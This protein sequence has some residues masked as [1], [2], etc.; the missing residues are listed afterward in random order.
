VIAFA[1]SPSGLLTQVP[2]PDG[3]RSDFTEGSLE[4]D[5]ALGLQS[6]NGIAITHDGQNL[7][8]ASFGDGA[9]AAFTRDAS[10]GFFEPLGV[11]LA[12]ADPACQATEPL[13]HAGFLR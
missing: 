3:C 11:C 5:A 7:Y 13:D 1:R 6:P 2:L 10:T 12:A 8:T 9:V 4:C